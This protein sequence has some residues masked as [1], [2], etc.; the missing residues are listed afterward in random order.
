MMIT[1]W[2]GVVW[3]RMPKNLRR[4]AVAATQQ[5]FTV[6]VAAIVM[7]HDG[8]ILLLDHYLRPKS[9][10]GLPGGFLD[11]GEQPAEGVRR[12]LLEETGL[13]MDGLK[14]VHVRVVG[15]HVEMI[16]SALADGVPE[17]D[18]YEIRGFRWVSESE[19]PREFDAEIRKLIRAHSGEWF[20]KKVASD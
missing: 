18:S 16:F 20:E 11:R 5:R 7:D 17:T 14:L 10:W 8:R 1:E 12:E 6:S 15:G 4:F 9:G 2:A 3:K 19:I 13:E